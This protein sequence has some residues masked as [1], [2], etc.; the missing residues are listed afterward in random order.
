MDKSMQSRLYE[1]QSLLLTMRDCLLL[2]GAENKILFFNK[3]AAHLLK[4]DNSALEQKHRL[5]GIIL[6]IAEKVLAENRQSE[7][8]LGIVVNGETQY[9]QVTGQ[10]VESEVSVPKMSTEGAEGEEKRMVLVI[11][12]EITRLHRLENLRREFVANVSHE[13]KTPIT[14]IKAAV[15]TLQDGAVHDAEMMPKFLD[16]IARQSDRLNNIIEDL[17][18]LSRL[19]N[20]RDEV[21]LAEAS[22]SDVIAEAVATC[23]AKAQEKNITIKLA[24]TQGLRVRMNSSLLEQAVMNLVDN[25]IK[26]SERG[27]S[28]NVV[29]KRNGTEIEISV[30]D[31]GRGIE[32]EHLSR[33]FERFY[34]VDKAR[35]RNAG[36][37][38]LGLSIVKH[39]AQVHG[40]RA[41]VSSVPGQGSNFS[42]FIAGV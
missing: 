32:P 10:L 31:Q 40:G 33:I 5:P 19:E 26:Y 20:E 18:S 6:E 12:H 3:A 9:F 14:S 27:T 13:L 2:F 17:L 29:A 28:I 25:A 41:T 11:L 21:Y 37:S 34:R 39:I 7:G 24:A 8:E 4:L 15:E 23:A 36:G 30:Q 22:V 42:L 1:P 38:G 16:I 35:S